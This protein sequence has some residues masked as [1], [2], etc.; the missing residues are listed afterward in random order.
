MTLLGRDAILGAD[1][2]HTQDVDV[3]EW[4]GKVRIRTLTGTE[5]DKFESG[6]H[7]NGKPNLADFRAKLCALCMVGEDGER[8]FAEKD[9]KELGKKSSAAL[10][11]VADA[12]TKLNGLEDKDVE[13]LTGN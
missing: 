2:L 1:D 13:E 12:A 9:V 7:N 10:S 6:I 8:M 11:R 4:G 5:R 3:P